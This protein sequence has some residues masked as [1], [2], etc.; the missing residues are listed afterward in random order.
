M[1]QLSTTDK[2]IITNCKNNFN[3]LKN[4]LSELCYAN[5]ENKFSSKNKQNN[6]ETTKSCFLL[7]MYF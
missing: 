7:F 1:S 3:S 2:S 5:N 4:T 6:F